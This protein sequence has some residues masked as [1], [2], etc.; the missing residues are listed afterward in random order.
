MIGMAV[1]FGRRLYLA[2]NAASV[3]ICDDQ[4]VS[5]WYGLPE[6]TYNGDATYSPATGTTTVDATA[7]QPLTPTVAVTPASSSVN[8][9]QNL[10]VSAKIMAR[11]LV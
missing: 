1:S 3:R 5:R 8:S 6:V 9:V 10:S 2:C 4:Q 7:P 11:L